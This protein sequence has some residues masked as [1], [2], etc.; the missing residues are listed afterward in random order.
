MSRKSTTFA[1]KKWQLWN[2]NLVLA[3]VLRLFVSTRTL[4]SVNVQ[5][6]NSLLLLVLT[7]QSNTPTNASA[8]SAYWSSLSKH[9]MSRMVFGYSLPLNP[10]LYTLHLKNRP[11]MRFFLHI[12]K[13]C[14][15][16][17]RRLVPLAQFPRK[18]VRE[19]LDILQLARNFWKIGSAFWIS[20]LHTTY[21]CK[22]LTWQ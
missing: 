13:I 21:I 9:A 19:M 7:W 3:V 10:T 2:T 18:Y 8:A 6:W 17:G 20:H 22:H 14:C 12:S 16:F 5:V 15:T 11:K 4:L 1:E